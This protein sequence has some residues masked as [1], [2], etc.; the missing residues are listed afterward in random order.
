[1]SSNLINLSHAFRNRMTDL[2]ACICARALSHR[3][4]EQRSFICGDSPEPSMLGKYT[5]KNSAERPTRGLV[6]TY[7]YAYTVYV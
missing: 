7:M 4:N 6:N 2:T 5:H 3:I 1:M